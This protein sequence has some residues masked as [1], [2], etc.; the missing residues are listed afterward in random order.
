AHN[1]AGSHAGTAR[2]PT[3]EHRRYCSKSLP[4]ATDVF[5]TGTHRTRG[6]S[7]TKRLAPASPCPPQGRRNVRAH[8]RREALACCTRGG[9]GNHPSRHSK[10]QR[11]TK[12]SSWV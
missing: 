12:H 3:P 10:L 6:V 1:Q 7:K 4:T 9:P 2:S 8:F 5:A 11:R